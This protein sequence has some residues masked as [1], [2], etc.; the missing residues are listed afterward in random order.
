[1]VK[2]LRKKLQL[3][4]LSHPFTQ[5][6]ELD[7]ARIEFVDYLQEMLCRAC[8]T[9]ARPHKQHIESSP[10]G[11]VQHAVERRAACL[12]AAESVVYILL[13]LR[14]CA[15]RKFDP[16]EEAQAAGKKERNLL[17]S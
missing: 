2:S 12:R 5:R 15:Y 14:D 10:A 9:V 11:I 8:E 3:R 1:M 16:T 13:L 17:G 4:L 7:V 6:H